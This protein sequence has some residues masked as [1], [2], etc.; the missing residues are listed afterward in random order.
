MAERVP[1]PGN[2]KDEYSE[3][4]KPNEM[5][6]QTASSSTARA[7]VP[8]SQELVPHNQSQY[9][10]FESGTYVVQV[11]KDQIYRIPP[12]ENATIVERH[13]DPSKKKKPVCCNF[14]CLGI[15]GFFLLFIILLI[16]GL[17][18]SVTMSKDPRFS[19]QRLVYNNKTKSHRPDYT[20]TL[21]SQNP[22]S[23]VAVLYK[24]GG[25]DA[26]LN[27]KTQE[28][29]TATYPSFE[30]DGGNSKEFALIFHGSKIKLPKDIEKSST[31]SKQKVH[32]KFSLSMDIPGRMRRGALKKSMIFHVECDFTVDTL[33]KGTRVLNQECRT[34]RT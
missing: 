30:Q 27:L 2:D 15:L 18:V 8:P 12:P 5:F 1:P 24:K 6:E 22:N 3:P 7:L 4:Q 14:I 17:Y 16:T 23:Q 20:I 13:R 26:F 21:K 34:N 19:V 32:V 11:P 10:T 31:S 28:I 9:A 25:D 33:V 29:A